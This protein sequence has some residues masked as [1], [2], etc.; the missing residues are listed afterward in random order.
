MKKID[1]YLERPIN[2]LG[3][4]GTSYPNTIHINT[5]STGD[6]Y[7]EDTDGEIL[8][9]S[10]MDNLMIANVHSIVEQNS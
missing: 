2:I 4:G 8:Y 3:E 10:E 5:T 7:I 6:E 9:L 1:L